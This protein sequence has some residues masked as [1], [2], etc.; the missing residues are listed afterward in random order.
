MGEIYANQLV[1]EGVVDR[2]AVDELKESIAHSL[3]E[4]QDELREH[5]S[6]E[7]EVAPSYER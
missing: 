5:G 4:I 6:T 1:E 3:R 2:E 7:D